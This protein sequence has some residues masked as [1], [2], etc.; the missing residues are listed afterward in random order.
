MKKE[1]FIF[2]NSSH[3]GPY[4]LLEMKAF[5]EKRDIKENTLIWKEGMQE[6]IP[7]KK[8]DLFTPALVVDEAPPPLPA[9]VFKKTT[10]PAIFIR[11]SDVE[12]KSSG[13]E[14]GLT[15]PKKGINLS[16]KIAAIVSILSI[17]VIGLLLYKKPAVPNFH[18]KSISP[19]NR[20]QLENQLTINSKNMSFAIALAMDQGNLWISTN[21]KENLDVTIDLKS[22]PKNVLGDE[23]NS[24]EV[25]VRLQGVI[26]NHLGHFTSMKMIKGRKFYPGEYKVHIKGKKIHWI[27]QYF[28][29]N[30]HDLNQ[31]FSFD[32]RSL[33]YS[34]NSREFERKITER[35]LLRI[36]KLLRPW[37]E[38]LEVLRTLKSL[39]EKNM[40][41]FGGELEKSSKGKDISNYEKS[42]IS[43]ISPIVQ[44][45]VLGAHTDLDKDPEFK[46]FNEAIVDFGKKTGGIA[47]EMITKITPIKNLDAKLKKKWREQFQMK[48]DSLGTMLKVYIGL[49]E[50]RIQ[51]IQNSQQVS[52]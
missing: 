31:D 33:I 2:I 14:I 7:L 20:E 52:K 8:V 49:I 43:E 40:E 6:W 30:K 51:E 12:A 37:Q 22:D 16:L 42:Y 28:K 32:F 29:I 45:L 15:L 5:Y 25:V 48:T 46:K 3:I 34:G 35:K 47:S 18:I 9:D 44:E 26:A 38:K 4:S 21:Q 17:L 24:E 11:E 41:L 50:S 36:N 10:I 13:E 19:F 1:W 39:T 27:N 23:S